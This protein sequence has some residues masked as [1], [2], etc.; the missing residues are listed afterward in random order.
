MCPALSVTV[1]VAPAMIAP[2]T[3]SVTTP[4]RMVA[5]PVGGRVRFCVLVTPA[6]MVLT[7][8]SEP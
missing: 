2:V 7:W 1:T 4:V 8:L 6:T 3:R 5:P